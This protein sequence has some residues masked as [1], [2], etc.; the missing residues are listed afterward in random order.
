[1]LHLR[2]GVTLA[3]LKPRS[4][5]GEAA[6]ALLDGALSNVTREPET[7]DIVEALEVRHSAA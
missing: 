3:R 2:A 4:G 7:A 6:R 1:M 5:N